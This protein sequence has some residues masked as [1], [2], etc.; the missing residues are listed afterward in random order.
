MSGHVG[1]QGGVHCRRFY[2]CTLNLL[3]IQALSLHSRPTPYGARKMLKMDGGFR[4]FYI[5]LFLIRRK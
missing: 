2:R 4:A 5:V 1:V 3:R